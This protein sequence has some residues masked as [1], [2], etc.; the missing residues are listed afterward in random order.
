MLWFVI[1]LH[2]GKE[3]RLGIYIAFLCMGYRHA[4]DLLWDY[5]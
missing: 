5:I 1:I 3:N 4:D 2:G